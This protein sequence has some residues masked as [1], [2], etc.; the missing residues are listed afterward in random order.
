MQEISKV[1]DLLRGRK[2]VLFLGSAISLFAPSSL[3]IGCS[4][5]RTILE[6]LA[7]P[8][9][10]LGKYVDEIEE[11]GLNPELVYQLIYNRMGARFFETHRI[12]NVSQFNSNHALLADL[13]R[14]GY[15]KTILTTNFDCLIERALVDRGLARDRD[16]TVYYDDEGFSRFLENSDRE[17][18]SVVKLHGSIEDEQS[19]VA[20]LE[21]TGRGLS[22]NQAD[23]LNEV[24]T[25]NHV[26]LVGYSGNDLDIYPK[27]SSMSGTA[28]GLL[29]NYNDELPHTVGEL[30]KSFGD[31]LTPLKMDLRELFERL[32][33]QV[34]IPYEKPDWAPDVSMMESEHMLESWGAGIEPGT[35]SLI[36]SSILSHMGQYEKSL[37]CLGKC[38]RFVNRKN[39]HSLGTEVHT[40]MGIAHGAAGR[41]MA[42]VK[43][44]ERVI[45]INRKALR[46]HKQPEDQSRIR[47]NLLR[48]YNDLVS[49]YY[50]MS[51]Y[52]EA[53]SYAGRALEDEDIAACAYLCDICNNMALTFLARR[54]PA[55]SVQCLEES[56][57]LV[58]SIDEP[59]RRAETL[60]DIGAIYYK[61]ARF[62]QAIIHLEESYAV[63]QQLGAVTDMVNVTNTRGA[64][65]MDAGLPSE[66]FSCFNHA[67][68]LAERIGNDRLK[69]VTENNIRALKSR[70]QSSHDQFL[71]FD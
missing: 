50:Q 56:C 7:R 19:I 12:L 18:V 8:H 54:Q 69:G 4:M 6:S 9:P 57:G 67:H 37:E 29:W 52:D 66:A 64:V 55:R 21:Q 60:H 17:R 25:N 61:Q 63:F 26:L 35:A 27:L 44:F 36:L 51:M 20:V 68:E 30:S 23:I 10:D 59:R 47:T 41:F 71:Q 16:F 40:E 28:C 39:A 70:G 14:A 5:R 13:A 32:A 53:L 42:A 15:L 22:L 43:C 31:R 48:A 62:D 65:Y 49:S 1:V 2:L 58:R 33:N 24:F 46:K 11:P 3:P 34:Q 38:L 45:K